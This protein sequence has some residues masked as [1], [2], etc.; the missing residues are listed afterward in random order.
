MILSLIF[1]GKGL[2]HIVT[3][4]YAISLAFMAILNSWEILFFMP[5]FGIGIIALILFAFAMAKGD[6]L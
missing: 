2:V 4:G 1:Y 3:I 6:W 5:I